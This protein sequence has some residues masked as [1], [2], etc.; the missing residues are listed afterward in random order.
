MD[1]GAVRQPVWVDMDSDGDLDLFVAF[2]DRANA[3]WLFR[4]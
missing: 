1:S 4:K 2:R 3:L